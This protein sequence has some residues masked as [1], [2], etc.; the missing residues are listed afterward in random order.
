MCAWSLS[1][2]YF[3]ASHKFT[4][5]AHKSN[6]QGAAN[7][8]SKRTKSQSSK[9]NWSESCLFSIWHVF[10]SCT[11]FD[12][13]FSPYC[14]LFIRSVTLLPLCFCALSFPSRKMYGWIT[15]TMCGCVVYHR[16]REFF[17][18][19][20]SYTHSSF[21]GWNLLLYREYWNVQASSI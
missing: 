21:S 13:L 9:I 11:S 6:I 12:C 5:I 16:E 19:H 14:F 7:R 18:F 8:R 15:C 4:Q 3:C 1:L 10:I 17:I 20:C 2:K